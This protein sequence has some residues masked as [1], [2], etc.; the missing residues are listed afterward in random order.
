M[1][2]CTGHCCQR[3]ALPYGPGEL[4]RRRHQIVDGDQ[5]ASMVVYLG[6]T[7]NDP[8]RIDG[9]SG[10]RHHWYRCRN[11]VDGECSIY[12]TRPKMCAEY[13]YGNRCKYAGCTWDAVNHDN[14]LPIVE[15]GASGRTHE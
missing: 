6:F 14:P 1:N 12:A 7:K 10:K 15:Y 11:F 4:R 9:P 2:R 8:P 3:F 13:P 5:I